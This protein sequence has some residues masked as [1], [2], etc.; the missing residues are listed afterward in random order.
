MAAMKITSLE[1]LRVH[2][3][4]GLSGLGETCS[5]WPGQSSLTTMPFSSGDGAG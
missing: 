3:D 5:T 2:T 1:T 4:E